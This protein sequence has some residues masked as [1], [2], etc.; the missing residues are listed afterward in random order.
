ML[1]LSLD[2]K[3]ADFGISIFSGSEVP[4]KLL[5]TIY[6]D[7]ELYVDNK[8]ISNDEWFKEALDI[9]YYSQLLYE[10]KPS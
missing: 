7:K 5:K 4:T 10:S 3:I 8:Q 1:T 6:N 2:I 9:R